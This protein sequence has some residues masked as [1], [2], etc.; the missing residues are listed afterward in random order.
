M[1]EQVYDSS[2]S[3]HKLSE[4]V[5]PARRQI[6]LSFAGFVDP[7]DPLHT[8]TLDNPDYRFFGISL[9][10]GKLDWLLMRKC[11]VLDKAVGNHDYAAS[12]HKWLMASIQLQ[13]GEL[14][15]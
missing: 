2:W 5:G 4:I 3:A 14:S 1:K 15:T 6:S 7:F 12:D 13:K 9:M 10:K 11:S 8:V